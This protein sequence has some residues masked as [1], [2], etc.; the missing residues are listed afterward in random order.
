MSSP[1]E[2][3]SSSELEQL[4][5]GRLPRQRAAEVWRHAQQCDRCRQLT[6]G[7][8]RR[9]MEN[10]SPGL[11]NTCSMQGNE[12]MNGQQADRRLN[13]SVSLPLPERIGRYRIER[14]LGSGGFG[15]VYLGF[16]ER[17]HR[18]VAV[19]VPR[20]ELV[21]SPQQANM[22]VEEARIVASLD[23]P[24]IVPVYDTGQTDDV[25]CYIV[26]K[27]IIGTSLTEKIQNG[28]MPCIEAARLVALILARASPATQFGR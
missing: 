28:P 12:A 11:E 25:A 1:D 21:S 15:I 18:Q 5:A 23:H 20:N 6:D 4:R 16:D 10:L 19:K 2:C 8:D 9:D 26:S 17:L 13:I 22:Y 27:Y 24:N 14:A 3:L 7:I